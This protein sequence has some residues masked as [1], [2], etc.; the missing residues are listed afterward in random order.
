[1]KKVAIVIQVYKPQF[2][3]NER[4]SLNQLTRVLSAYPVVLIAPESMDTKA[5]G[6]LLKDQL[7][8]VVTF[9]R[10]YFRDL[11]G[12]NRLLLSRGYYKPFLEYDYILIHHT[13]S[14]IFRNELEFW[15]GR[16]YDN[17][18]API[19]Y[20]DD[21]PNPLHYICTGNGG[22]CL[23]RVSTFYELSS[24]FKIVYRFSDISENFFKY[25]WRGRLYR[26]PYYLLM[27]STLGARL[28]SNF[29]RIR[30]NEDVIWGH[31]VPKY[32]SGFNNAP[33]ED[34]LRFSMEFNCN[35]LLEINQGQLPFGCH[36]WYRPMFKDFWKPH[37]ESLGYAID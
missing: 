23:R 20:Y 24:K 18:G 17:I 25:N 12:Y 19:Y 34:G 33:F 35:R 28:N 14:F 16:G 21:T 30:Q 5:Y 13:D 31:Y 6:E 27:L 10:K 32:I 26:M 37:I 4:I 2:S 1:M 29:N 7:V 15:A 9:S 3:F 22:L 8:N 11:R 36:G